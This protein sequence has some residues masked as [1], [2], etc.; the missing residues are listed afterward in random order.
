MASQYVSLSEVT[1]SDG[2]LVPFCPLSSLAVS[3]LSV[4][5]YRGPCQCVNEELKAGLAW[6]SIYS[7]PPPHPPPPSLFL[8]PSLSR[9]LFC[10]S[11]LLL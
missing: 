9:S 11:S 6:Y 1:W 10:C 3:V 2:L 5:L 4:G 7:C 8:Y